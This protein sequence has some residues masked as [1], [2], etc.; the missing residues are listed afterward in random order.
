M[1]HFTETNQ[2]PTNEGWYW[3]LITSE[4]YSEWLPVKISVS[5]GGI[6]YIDDGDKRPVRLDDFLEYRR[7]LWSTEEI[8]TP[9][10]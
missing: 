4:K 3:M 7:V 5:N 1:P 10:R 8:E 6:L 2:P 9:R